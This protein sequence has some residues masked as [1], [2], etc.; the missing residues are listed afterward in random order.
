MNVWGLYFSS[1]VPSV[2][3][4]REPNIYIFVFTGLKT[5]DIKKFNDAKHDIRIFA[6]AIID[7]GYAVVLLQ[8]I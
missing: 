8:A 5:I 1:Y 3:N 2:D 4:W 7:A 6:L